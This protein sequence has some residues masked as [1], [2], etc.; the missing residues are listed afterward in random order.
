MALAHNLY[1]NM[2]T[3]LC[4]YAKILILLELR[5]TFSQKPVPKLSTLAD[6]M[7]RNCRLDGTLLPEDIMLRHR[8]HLK[9]GSAL[10][11]PLIML[12]GFSTLRDEARADEAIG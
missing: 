2:A 5:F 11:M 8:L 10:F 7:S 1:L 6:L 12:L 4:Q 9:N 3:V